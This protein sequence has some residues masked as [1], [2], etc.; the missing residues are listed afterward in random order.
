MLHAAVFRSLQQDVDILNGK[1]TDSN[2]RVRQLQAEMAMKDRHDAGSNHNT[3]QSE[4][5]LG[6]HDVL[7]QHADMARDVGRLTAQVSS[8]TCHVYDPLLEAAFR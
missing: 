7:L 6:H 2:L 3:V 8:C 1:L 4:T 5:G